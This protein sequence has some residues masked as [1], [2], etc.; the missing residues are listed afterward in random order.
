MTDK[1][2]SLS[3]TL[4][5]LLASDAVKVLN[6]AIIIRCS[7]FASPLIF[8]GALFSGTAMLMM[9]SQMAPRLCCNNA[10]CAM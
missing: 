8:A 10:F 1:V 3:A 7:S 2:V 4:V 6:A 5:L 9:S